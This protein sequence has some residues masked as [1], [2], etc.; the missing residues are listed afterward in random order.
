M[1]RICCRCGATF[2]VSQSGR[3]VRKEECNYHYGKVKENKV[4]GGMETR[5]TCCEGA[6]GTPG[7]Q[8]FKL[9]VHDAVS[10]YGFVSS[11]QRSLHD[12]GCP[13]VFALDCEMCYTTHGLELARV[14]VVNSS[15][16]VIYDTFVKPDNEV[17]DYNTRFSGV[18]E[19]DLIGCS[20]SIRDVQEVLQSFISADTI[21]IGHSLEKDLCALKFRF[22]F[23]TAPLWTLPWYSR[24]VSDCRTNEGSVA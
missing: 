4:P 8:V 14:T 23:F 19:E 17:I 11:P 3:H 13:G 21:L 2:S 20:S 22:S 10:L 16:Q 6:I 5:Y 18:T 7:C 12:S 1:K 9:H 15:L 24:T